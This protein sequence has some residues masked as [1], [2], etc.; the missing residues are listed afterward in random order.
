MSVTVLRPGRA[1]SSGFS[2]IEVLVALVIVSVGLLGLAAMMQA[3]LSDNHT[4][5]LQTLAT[6]DAENLT[7]LM[8]ANMTGVLDGD[9]VIGSLP[10]SPP[11]NLCRTVSAPCTP[12]EEAQADLWNFARTLQ[13]N[14][15]NPQ[16]TVQCVGPCSATTPYLITVTW[17]VANGAHTGEETVSYSTLYQP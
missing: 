14:L 12:A 9:Y 17:T 15:P 3:G 1:R 6:I 11:A 7:E 16:A 4:A 10:T 8:R 5:E 2:L 13:A